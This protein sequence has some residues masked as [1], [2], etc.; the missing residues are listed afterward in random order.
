MDL[1]AEVQR[2]INSVIEE[3]RKTKSLSKAYE[4]LIWL[5]DIE[6]I[7]LCNNLNIVYPIDYEEIK[8]RFD[9]SRYSNQIEQLCMNTK[10][11]MIDY[12]R[13]MCKIAQYFEKKYQMANEI[14]YDKRVS[15]DDV[16]MLSGEFLKYYDKE[17]FNLYEKLNYEGRI[18]IANLDK[19][20]G[21]TMCGNKVVKPYVLLNVKICEGQFIDQ[22]FVLVHEI[23]HAYITSKQDKLKKDEAF[24]LHVNNLEE[25]YSL[26]SEFLI[27]ILQRSNNIYLNVFLVIFSL[28]N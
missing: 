26:F 17:I 11:S 12:D 2:D 25:V 8:L 6:S 7:T 3:L 23:I 22:I 4:F 24:R 10:L 5:K 16:D 20:S 28:K 21:I 19:A 9:T 15:I 27:I 13:K 14:V 18:F 1:E